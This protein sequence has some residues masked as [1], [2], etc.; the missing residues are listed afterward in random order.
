[1]S[2]LNAAK[3]LRERRI[4]TLAIGPFKYDIALVYVWL[5]LSA[6]MG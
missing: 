6:E 4:S 3:P 5:G 1:V 2:P